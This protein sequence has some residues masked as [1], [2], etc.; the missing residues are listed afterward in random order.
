MVSLVRQWF[1]K[2]FPIGPV[3]TAMYDS[4]RKVAA[5]DQASSG[6]SRDQQ[7]LAQLRACHDELV[8]SADDAG[9]RPSKR[10]RSSDMP[11]NPI[12]PAPEAARRASARASVVHAAGRWA[13]GGSAKQA[14][15]DGAGAEAAS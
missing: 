15:D 14:T 2:T 11:D 10:A 4:M 3:R 12:T 5:K 13:A 7:R 9:A 8:S 6:A 1:N